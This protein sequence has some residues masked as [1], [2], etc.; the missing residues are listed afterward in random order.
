MNTSSSTAVN[1]E[2]LIAGTKKKDAGGEAFKKG[3][4]TEDITMRQ[5][6]LCLNGLQN[7]KAF[8]VFRNDQQTPEKDPL[9]QEIQ[10]VISVLYS[11]MAGTLPALKNDADNTKALFRRAQAY[12]QEGNVVGAR[13]DLDKLSKNNPDDPGIKRE[14]Y[15]LRQKEKEQDRKQAK[16]LKGLFARMQR[17]DEREEA[18]RAKADKEKQSTESEDAKIQEINTDEPK[19]QEINADEPKIQETNADE[20][21]IQEINA[22]EPKIQEILEELNTDGPKIQEITD[23]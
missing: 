6:L 12:I 1:K 13:Q 2:K 20:P 18:E 5:A 21:K 10:K 3:N 19:I 16:D 7:N 11:N 15:K 9:Q 4:M 14:Y 8:A 17:E 22:D 23:D